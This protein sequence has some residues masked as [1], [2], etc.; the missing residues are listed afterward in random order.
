MWLLVSH[1]R[2]LSEFLGPRV[3]TACSCLEVGQEE[4]PD[5]GPDFLLLAPLPTVHF[6]PLLPHCLYTLLAEVASFLL[7]LLILPWFSL[8]VLVRNFLFS[9]GNDNFGRKLLASEQSSHRQRHTQKTSLASWPFP[10]PQNGASFLLS[11]LF[12]LLAQFQRRHEP[13]GELSRAGLKWLSLCPF[14][15][16]T[17]AWTVIHLSAALVSFSA[18]SAGSPSSQ[19]W[20]LVT[21]PA[22]Q[23]HPF[24][25]GLWRTLFMPR[26]CFYLKI[27]Q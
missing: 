20:I 22:F 24:K 23:S 4:F 17:A 3:C 14:P 18:E 8:T 21:H 10:G 16:N 7:S 11:R 2:K 15:V 12:I 25:T 19:V 13:S 26:P 6:S 9:V 5:L 27:S 1:L